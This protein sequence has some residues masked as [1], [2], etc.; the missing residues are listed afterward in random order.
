MINWFIEP[1]QY[2]FI[3]RALI[4]AVVVGIVGSVLGTYVILRGMAFFGDALAHTILPG[5]VV[6]FLFGWPL[7]VGALVM[8]LLTALGI[9]ALSGQGMV[10]EDTAI[11]VIFAGAFALGVALLSA[12][13]TYTVD[14]AHFL[15]GNLLGVSVSDLWLSIILGLIVLLAIFLFYKE[16]LVISFDPVLATTLRLP[17]NFLRYLL[18]VL[19]AVTI[20][21]SLQVVGI[22]LMMAMLVTPAASA[23]LLTR[24]LPPMMA[25]AAVIGTFSSVSGL[26]A[27]YY[28]DIASGPAIVLVATL[29]FGFVFVFAPGRGIAWQ[30]R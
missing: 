13:N 14:L 22:A 18:L 26:Y 4:A 29:I 9:G 7:A 5:V 10:K 23:S 8:G 1:L 25:I 20:V 28:F 30:K 12:S 27:S 17:A 2:S 19:I 3:L 11:G 21:V 15:F 6:A 16:F 24:R